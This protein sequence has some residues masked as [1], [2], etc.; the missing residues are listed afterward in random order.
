MLEHLR[1]AWAGLWTARAL[2]ARE[3]LHAR[4]SVGGGVLVQRV[5]DA[6][7]SGVLHTVNTAAGRPR[8]M[9]LNAGLGLGEGVVSGLVAADQVTVEKD[10]ALSGDDLHFRYLTRDKR[11]R[12][13][14]AARGGGGT[15]LAETLYHQRLRPALEYVE[16]CE[17]VHAAARLEAA[18]GLPLDLEFAI[19]GATLR[20]LQ[21]RPVPA[22]VAVW[23]ETV[24]RWPLSPGGPR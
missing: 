23:R 21:V 1:L 4:A 18:F 7:V 11:E 16:L 12:V 22:A 2:H 14:R 13:V 8:E 15:V 10:A 6:R 9:L 5:V 17:L 3:A 19:E 20:L 24:E